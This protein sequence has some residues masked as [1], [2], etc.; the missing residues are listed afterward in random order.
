MLVRDQH[1][2][3]YQSAEERSLGPQ[4]VIISNYAVRYR[5]RGCSRCLAR[6][7]IFNMFSQSTM[8]IVEK[9]R[10]L[11]C[12]SLVPLS[13]REASMDVS[14]MRYNSRALFSKRKLKATPYDSSSLHRANPNQ[15]GNARATR[16]F[17]SGLVYTESCS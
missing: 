11:G 6:L 12:I 2:R 17:L 10:C 7:H 15:A 14:G 5:A 16:S 3:R 4:A 1:S 8:S 13:N 9:N